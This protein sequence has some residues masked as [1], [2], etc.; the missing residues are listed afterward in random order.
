MM[1]KQLVIISDLHFKKDEPFFSVQK[2]FMNWFVKQDFNNENNVLIDLGDLFDNSTPN[3][4]VYDFVISKRKEM[5]FK[6]DYILAGNHCYNR[7]RDSYAEEPLQNKNNTKIIYKPEVIEIEC[8]N[9]Y[10]TTCLKTLKCLFLPFL[11]DRIFF[12]MSMKDYYE[13]EEFL[14]EFNDSY[15]F[16]FYHFQDS[17]MKFSADD[18]NGIDIDILEG[19]KLGGH[20]HKRQSNYLGSPYPLR[21]DERGKDSFILLIDME[22]KK[23]EY[24]QIPKF[25]DYEEIDY[26]VDKIP[27]NKL[28]KFHYDLGIYEYRIYDIIDAPSE[29]S[30]REKFKGLYIR[31]VKLKKDKSEILEEENG[32]EEKKTIEVYFDNFCKKNNIEKRIREKIRSKI[33]YEKDN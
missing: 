11:Y 21:Y 18:D 27:E 17:S 4:S 33:V 8:E 23:R 2:E 29:D 32:T 9:S 14:K 10:N 28:W 3:P 1:N 13:S 16:I 30:A 25:L 15:D 6:E 24:I 31:E 26:N 19:E 5:K 22:T 7:S 20:I 12:N